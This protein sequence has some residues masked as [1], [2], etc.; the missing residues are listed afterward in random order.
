METVGIFSAAPA[1]ILFILGGGVGV[2]LG[3]PPGPEDPL[4]AKIAPE[5]C[6]FF[7]S[8]AGMATPD[9][10]SA[11]NVE[12]LLAEPEVQRLLSQVEQELISAMRKAADREGDEA[13]L[14]ARVAPDLV[15]TLLTR[16][17][18]IF[19][20]RLEVGPGGPDVSAAL[21]VNLDEKKD[22]VKASLEQLQSTLLGPAVK[23]E[24]AGGRQTYRIQLGAESPPIT[25]TVLGKYL[26]VGMG[27]D[28]ISGVI[29]RV[30]TEAPQW[31]T[32]I[33]KT[34]PVERQSTISYVNIKRL[35]GTFAPLGGPPVTAVLR[36][37]GLEGVKSLTSVTGLEGE[38]FVGRTLL[39]IEGE[40]AGLVR[41][42]SDQPLTADDLAPIPADSTL[43]LALRLDGAQVLDILLE[44][45]GQ[46]E[47]RGR[48]EMLDGIDEI[49]AALGIDIRTDVL[50]SL[51]DV[52]CAYNSPGEGGLILTGLT[53]TVSVKDRDRFVRVYDRLIG[54]FKGSLRGPDDG[55]FRRRG[56][57]LKSFEI[58]GHEV[59]VL[60]GID[61]EFPFA[62]SWCLTDSHLVLA[63]FPQNIKAILLRDD[64]YQ[65]LAAAPAVKTLLDEGKR[66]SLLF[67]QDTP[68]L[69]KLAYPFL[70]MLGAVASSELQREGIDL[71]VSLL[72]SAKAILPHLRPGV[73]FVGRSEAGIEFETR[74]SF[75]GGNVGVTLPIAAGLGVPAVFSARKAAR[76]M[77]SLNNLK[78]LAIAMLNHEAVHNRFPAAYT[79]DDDDKPLLSW[80]VKI[81]PYIEGQQLYEQFHLD[82]PWDSEHN[83]ELI[84]SM[85][86]T[87]MSAG[88]H[89]ERG[90]THYQTVR[91]DGTMFSGKD[92]IGMAQVRDGMSRTI[93]IVEADKPVVWTKPDDFE[94]DADDPFRGLGGIRGGGFQAVFAD[95]ACRLIP[96]HLDPAD[97]VRLFK[98]ADGEAVELP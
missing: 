81:L 71:D 14:L 88:S 76:R 38:G 7:A 16:P 30:K 6:V 29:A 23:E 9:A 1:I 45:V 95:G 10:D 15:K 13:V 25:W 47:P 36:A 91:G 48:E 8:W 57:Q 75:P 37:T 92:G 98:M 77:Q 50:E 68:E 46:I 51:G 90:K 54:M 32:D 87:F 73:M 96:R 74:Q 12:K 58:S 3:V 53:A 56:L 64:D 26:V 43:A 35:V 17:A 80:R 66:P 97:L 49:N 39:E 93:L 42:M 19:V 84:G 86:P 31:L 4:L 83:S 85:P 11:N 44:T 63:L 60:S 89:T 79:T 33:R 65:S 59:F 27:D 22:A 34:L 61:N 78:Q 67:Y 72:P 55:G 94:Y 28:A 62:P 40:A 5:E 52:W 24:E 20:S 69:F 70:Q 2:P 21:V 82:E 41:L 18:A